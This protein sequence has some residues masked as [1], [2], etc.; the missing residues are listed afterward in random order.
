[1]LSRRTS[2]L[3]GYGN[4]AFRGNASNI[5]FVQEDIPSIGVRKHFTSFGHELGHYVQEDIPSRGVRKL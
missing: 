3:E 1:M 2:P 5:S 4:K